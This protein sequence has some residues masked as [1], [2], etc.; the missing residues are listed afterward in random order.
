MSNEEKIEMHDHWKD[1]Y[2]PLARIYREVEKALPD[3]KGKASDREGLLFL[4]A[5]DHEVKPEIVMLLQKMIE[6]IEN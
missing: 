6:D 4:L 1:Y 2:E 5:N 3:W